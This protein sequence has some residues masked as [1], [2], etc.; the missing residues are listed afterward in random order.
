M[1]KGVGTALVTPFTANGEVDFS[2]LTRLVEHQIKGGT[3]FL[4]VMGTT[5]EPATMT[6]SERKSV[7]DKVL[8][9]N[10]GR[11]KIVF[12]LGGNNTAQICHALESMDTTGINGILSVSPY[13]N[14][15]TQDGIIAHYTAIN[16]STDLPVIVYNVP[17]RTSSNLTAQTTLKLAELQNMVAVKEASGNM[18]QIMTIIA[19]REPGF[20]VISGDDV[21]NLPIL[22]CGGEGIISVV[23]NAYP[24]IMKQMVAAATGGDL[25]TARKAHYKLLKMTDLM[26]REGNPGG[27]KEALRAQGICDSNLRLP[28]VQVSDQLRKAIQHEN[29]N[30]LS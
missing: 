23:S 27:V 24:A 19:N 30:I 3:D 7:L 22:T 6:E 20:G 4:V 26:F 17:G 14:K 21:L 28:L 10:N 1:F 29:D 11:L 15:P 2:G 25:T 18:E 13:Y 8:E 9:I 16:G 12:G 5:G